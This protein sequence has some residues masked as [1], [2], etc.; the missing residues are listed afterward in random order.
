MLIP[1]ALRLS[2]HS[3]FKDV[4]TSL[5]WEK[6][7]HL[8]I[9]IL[10][11]SITIV[12]TESRCTCELMIACIEPDSLNGVLPAQV[13]VNRRSVKPQWLRPHLA[14]EWPNLTQLTTSVREECKVV[15]HQGML[16]WPET[17]ASW[18]KN[19]CRYDIGNVKIRD[20]FQSYSKIMQ[21]MLHSS[22]IKTVPNGNGLVPYFV[23]HSVFCYI[24]GLFKYCIHIQHWL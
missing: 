11:T 6:S 13:V 18:Q 7:V 10:Q 14:R 19:L 9:T 21:Q 23:T 22:L 4:F 16:T 3:G 17:T 12:E 24:I 2:L 8:V 5:D 20:E 1:P 15:Y